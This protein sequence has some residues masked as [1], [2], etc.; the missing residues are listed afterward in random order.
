L[1]PERILSPLVFSL[2]L[3]LSFLS[4]ILFEGE[5]R[6]TSLQGIDAQVIARLKYQAATVLLKDYGRASFKP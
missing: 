6:K 5:I 3:R 1:H 4:Q 2:L